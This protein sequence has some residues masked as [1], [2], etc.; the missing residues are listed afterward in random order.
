[1]L[2]DVFHKDPQ[3]DLFDLKGISHIMVFTALDSRRVDI[4]T[5]TISLKRSQSK[6]P[7]VELTEI[8][9][10]ICTQIR[11]AKFANRG[12][13]KVSSILSE[14]N[15]VCEML[16]LIFVFK[17]CTYPSLFSIAETKS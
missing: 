6:L 11:R 5:Y 12:V 14:V 4:R 2:L 8:G 16:G 1:M 13:L 7:R 9:P 17:L 10:R 15:K 3:V